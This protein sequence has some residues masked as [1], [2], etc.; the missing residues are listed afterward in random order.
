MET[1]VWFPIAALL[2]LANVTDNEG[3]PA[4][5]GEVP[6]EVHFVLGDRYNNKTDLRKFCEQADRLLMAIQYGRYLHN[7]NG[8]SQADLP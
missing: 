8:G 5:L 7:D 6:T 2:T 4:H 1:A 3:A